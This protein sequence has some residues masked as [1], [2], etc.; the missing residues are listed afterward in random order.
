MVLGKEKFDLKSH[1]SRVSSEV[2]NLK[3]EKEKL[4]GIN[5]EISMEVE[6]LKT[7]SSELK[8][9]MESNKALCDE[10]SELCKKM[11]TLRE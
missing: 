8:T 5:Y 10:N 9:Q 1:L 6:R 3:R 4:S 11:K 7:G 2:D